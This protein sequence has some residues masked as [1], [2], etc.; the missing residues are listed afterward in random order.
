MTFQNN[1]TQAIEADRSISK[2]IGLAV[3]GTIFSFFFGY[4][5]KLFIFESR[6]I[7]LL[8]SFLSLLFFL[9]IFLL[10]VFFIK[11][12]PKTSQIILLES[13]A[14]LAAFY[15]QLSI[16]VAIGALAS[17][18]ILLWANY[19]GRLELENML[20]I[21]F[22]RVSKKVLPKAIAALA[23]FIGIV[24][25]NIGG[26]SEKEFFIP[27]T[28]FDKIVLSITDSKI[29]QNFFP[30]FDLSLPAGELIENLAKNR[31]EQNSQM[32]L[33]SKSAKKQ[34]IN[35]T[36]KELE[37]QFSDFLGIPINSKTKTSEALYQAMINKFM[38]LPENIKVAVPFG[39]AALIFLTIISFILPI[40]WLASIL[41]Y[42][43]YEICLALGF[44]VIMLEGRSREII[45]LK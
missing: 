10:G 11:S 15:E 33:L 17:F 14:F 4:F 12:W 28:A 7:F 2:I 32:K 13:L 5:L 23:L 29:I 25:V 40:R 26:V 34:L 38:A 8:V 27:Q 16:N 31:I 41:A 20:K 44:S 45:I 3:S 30:G 21:R 24:Y 9:A 42:F 1:Q 19:S 35:Q 22:W 36:A 43:A 6:T 37:K 39:V 18:L